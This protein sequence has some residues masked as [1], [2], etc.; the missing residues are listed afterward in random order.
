MLGIVIGVAAVIV[1]VAIGTRRAHSVQQ[2]INALGSN[3][4]IILP[5]SLNEGG[6]RTGRRRRVD[7]DAG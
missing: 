7:A 3:M 6:V 2:Q 4:I 1:T 5:G